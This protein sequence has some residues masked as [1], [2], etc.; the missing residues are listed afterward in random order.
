MNRDPASYAYMGPPEDSRQPPRLIPLHPLLCLM[1]TL[2]VVLVLAVRPCPAGE[3][4][5][6]I[7]QVVRPPAPVTV[8]VG[9]AVAPGNKA[10]LRLTGDN[11]LTELPI[12]GARVKRGIAEVT[13][14]V[15]RKG[16]SRGELFNEQGERLLT[17]PELKVL[18]SDKPSIAKVEPAASYKTEGRY[19]VEVTGEHFA[20][21]DLSVRI[22]GIPVPFA[23]PLIDWEGRKAA[24]DC[25]QLP[26]LIGNSRTLRIYGVSLQ[27]RSADRPM[28][29]SVEVDNLVSNEVPLLLSPVSRSTPRV[30]ALAVLGVAVL[31][32]YVVARRKVTTAQAPDRA[33]AT[34]TYLFLD[35]ATNTYSLS[36]LQLILWAGAAI[37]AYAY[38]AA[39]Q[40]LVQ[41]RW[42]LPSVPEGL[43]M[44]LGLS[45][46]TTVL[47]VATSENWG[48]KGAGPVH[49]GLADFVTS[50]GVFAPE[51]V[52]YFLWT[53]LGVAGF[54]SATLAQDP[55]TVTQLPTVPDNFIPL[56]G[57][58]SLGYLAGKVVRKPGPVIRELLPRPPYD[59]PPPDGIRILGEHLSPRAEVWL[60]GALLTADEVKPKEGFPPNAEFVSEL[61]VRPQKVEKPTE[62][63][64]P[65]KVINPDRQAAEM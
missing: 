44:L 25:S 4:L 62:G 31:L 52:Q 45:V 23:T 35:P 14:P 6:L 51:R 19:D 20:P 33:Y 65:V 56:M 48:N 36:R 64:A 5:E 26:C 58:S 34:L 57:A 21:Q 40:F 12:D 22:N 7:P 2:M 53:L 15:L 3:A 16:T 13:I 27:G 29:L 43:P 17:G 18:A 10:Y 54:V 61:V 38:L 1:S 49:P 41:W 46:G 37:V 39:S 50:G 59:A 47:A 30:I 11:R 9:V 8:K 28:R 55:A 32:V 42:D 63:M 60:N 24:K